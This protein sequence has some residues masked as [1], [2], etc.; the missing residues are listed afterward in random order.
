MIFNRK[1]IPVE[2]NAGTSIRMLNDYLTLIAPKMGYGYG[3]LT[4]LEKSNE[5]NVLHGFSVILL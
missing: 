1:S 5:K 3:I 4:P 2:D